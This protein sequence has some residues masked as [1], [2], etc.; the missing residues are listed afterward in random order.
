MILHSAI[1]AGSLF[2][3]QAPATP[4]DTRAVAAMAQDTAREA[5]L[6]T[7]REKARQRLADDARWYG[8]DELRDIEWRYQSAH[9]TWPRLP[10]EDKRPQLIALIEKYPRS[11]RAGCALIELAYGATGEGKQQY[12]ETAIR[13]HGDAWCE[14]GA[15]V[16]ANARALLATH[17]AGLD[18]YDDAER[19]AREIAERFPGS[20]DWAGAPLDDLLPALK[21]LRPSK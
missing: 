1:L 4:Q 13:R 16:G 14:N 8:P 7:L 18:R 15:Q 6:A 3:A 20:V 9:P 2:L 11:T 19:L 12:L 17:Y 21:L 10:A 5:R